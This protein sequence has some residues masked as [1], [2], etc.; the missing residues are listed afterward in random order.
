VALIDGNGVIEQ[1]NRVWRDFSCNNGGSHEL[2]QGAGINYFAACE[3]DDPDGIRAINGIRQVL[4]GEAQIFR[5]E[6]PCDA[7][8]EKRWFLLTA[9]SLESNR[10]KLVVTHTDITELKRALSSITQF[11]HIVEHA[12][13]PLM[14][15]DRDFR[16][17][18]DNPFHAAML[19]KMP[20][21]V[22]GRLSSEV[23]Q[24][25]L[26]AKA[27]PYLKQCLQG[28]PQHYTLDQTYPDGRRY[29]FEVKLQPYCVD[30]EVEG[31]V[32]TMHDVTQLTE[33][34]R[35]LESQQTHLEHLIDDRTAQLVEARN[36]TQS[37]LDSS[38]DGIIG[39]DDQNN[40]VLC[41]PAALSLLGYTFEEL[42]GRN[43]HGAIHYLHADGSSFPEEQCPT[44]EA[45]QQGRVVRVEHDVFWH[46]E[47]SPIQV[48]AVTHPIIEDGRVKGAVMNFRDIS[49]RV[50]IEAERENARRTAEQLAQMKSE[51]LSNM[52]HEVRTP[53]NGILG[54]AKIGLRQSRNHPEALDQFAAILRSGN[55]LLAIV[56]DILARLIHRG[57]E[58]CMADVA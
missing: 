3:K 56:N 5:M 25:D 57:P 16:F 48:T 10:Q 51:F 2:T 26:Y 32:V 39:I 22:I 13:M 29:A 54:L 27:E 45:I 33:A 40:I 24:A 11:K 55:L 4:A 47:G 35:L 36:R 50:R 31:V 1:V 17:I 7:P 52:S 28:A 19:G 21:D 18:I 30:Q 14:L 38:A 46:K 9:A 23:L 34:K 15:V 42:K 8:T 37:V 53:L 12:P 49:E 58:N 6:Y 20:E 44:S 41:N 43:A